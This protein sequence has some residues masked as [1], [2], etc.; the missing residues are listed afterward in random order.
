MA[1]QNPLNVRKDNEGR[2]Y[3]EDLK[4]SLM[5]PDTRA[6]PW[7]E[8]KE[9]ISSS[10]SLSPH[11]CLRHGHKGSYSPSLEAELKKA[12]WDGCGVYELGLMRKKHG[13][14]LAKAA[15]YVGSTCR[16]GTDHSL[17]SRIFEYVRNGSHKA[18]LIDAALDHRLTVYVRVI[19]TKG[20][21]EARA[22]EDELL[23]TYNYAWNDVKNGQIREDAIYQF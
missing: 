14:D 17:G 11:C 1:K 15:F 23:T 13:V 10:L 5:D 16:E 9:I 3:K 22:L 4:I 6:R 12:E 21:D 8:W 7:S 2:P 18:D 20:N 19:Q